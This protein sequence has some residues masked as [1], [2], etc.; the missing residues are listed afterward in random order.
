MPVNFQVVTLS[1]C[2][3]RLEPHVPSILIAAV[4]MNH[5]NITSLQ[6]EVSRLDMISCD[7]TVSSDLVCANS[8]R[9]LA[10]RFLT[11]TAIPSLS[12]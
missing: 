4:I 6:K 10:K 8:R 3:I 9:L 7:R 1:G 5:M 11:T 2:Q 12:S